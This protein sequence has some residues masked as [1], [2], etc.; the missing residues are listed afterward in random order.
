[1]GKNLKCKG[2]ATVA[3]AAADTLA[4]T[5]DQTHFGTVAHST[6]PHLNNPSQCSSLTLLIW[7]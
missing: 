5:Q 4:L 1:M 2:V 3:L 7:I 6:K